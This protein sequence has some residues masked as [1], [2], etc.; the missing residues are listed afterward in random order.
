MALLLLAYLSVIGAAFSDEDLSCILQPRKPRYVDYID[1]A[2][3]KVS[4]VMS[5]HHRSGAETEVIQKSQSNEDSVQSWNQGGKAMVSSI[6][7]S[8]VQYFDGTLRE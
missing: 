7:P 8:R 3:A 5:S 6:F 4:K 1:H 2:N